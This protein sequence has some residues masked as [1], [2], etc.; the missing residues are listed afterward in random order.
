MRTLPLSEHILLAQGCPYLKRFHCTWK[1]NVGAA[2][3]LECSQLYIAQSVLFPHALYLQGNVCWS[4]SCIP[5]N[6][7]IHEQEDHKLKFKLVAKGFISR[8]YLDPEDGK[9]LLAGPCF[10]EHWAPQI[11]GLVKI[12][13]LQLFCEQ[14]IP[15]ESVSV[16]RCFV[17]RPWIRW[18]DIHIV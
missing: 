10:C 8:G 3:L 6:F 1:F 14:S 7:R 16:M 4:H 15:Y 17:N 2:R 11:R 18:S 9:S 13:P 5:F 12:G